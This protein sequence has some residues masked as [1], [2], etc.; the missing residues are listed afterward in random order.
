MVNDLL[1]HPKDLIS[2]LIVE[3]EEV[4]AKNLQLMLKD[5]NF[6]IA[7]MPKSFD[8]A[9]NTVTQV[10]FDIALIDINLHGKEN[11]IELGKIINKVYNKPFI[12]ITSNSDKTSLA[13]A[14]EAKPSAYLVKPANSTSL[15]IA[16][17]NAI[18][19]FYFNNNDV[20]VSADSHFFFFV[21]QGSKYKKLSWTDIVYL[22]A[23]KNYLALFN[24]VDGNVYYIRSSLQ[25]TLQQIIPKAL[26]KHYVQ[27]NRSEAINTK[28]IEELSAT[29]VK[30]KYRNFNVT[31]LYYKELRKQLNIIS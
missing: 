18:N 7:A 19:N 20:A 27:I 8:E 29:E 22:E 3:D 12:F 1:S 9:L 26:V 15:F 11:G 24:A 31:E 28:Y 6:E 4:W 17:Q 5:L 2:V 13:K 14:S 25:K 23:G 30:T 16:I 10:E 21:K